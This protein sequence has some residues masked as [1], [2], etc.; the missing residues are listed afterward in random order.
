MVCRNCARNSQSGV[1]V[2]WRRLDVAALPRC[3][4]I[5]N[6][7]VG[8]L[9]S[10][11]LPRA[12]SSRQGGLDRA[13]IVCRIVMCRYGACS[14]AAK[15]CC[16]GIKREGEAVGA[17]PSAEDVTGVVGRRNRVECFPGVVGCR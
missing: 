14:T 5:E 3:S 17:K 15:P 10:G 11:V 12:A 8:S 2:Q 7:G 4:V 13:Y 9:E 16:G 1:G 6:E